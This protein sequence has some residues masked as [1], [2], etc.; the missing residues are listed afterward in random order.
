M[1][2]L[3]VRV[4]WHDNRWNGTVCRS[5]TGNAFCAS[6]DRIREEKQ[7]DL[8]QPLHERCF[9]TLS[10][11]E[12]P[13]CKAESG[14]FMNE[15][16]WVRLFEHP[17]KDIPKA[18]A[19]HGHLKPT[20]IPVPPYC[21]FAV[22]FWWML[23]SNQRAIQ[24]GLA[25]PLPPDEKA[26]FPTPWVFGRAR[27]EA[28]VELF[29][30]KRL[31][32]GES[33]ALFYCKAGHPLGEQI[34][35][36]IVGVGRITK[37]DSLR[38]YESA[39]PDSYP[40]WDR[41][42]RHSVR[43]DG[44][45]GF[46]LPYHDYLVPTGDEKEDERRARLLEEIVVA[47][48]EEHIRDFSY[49]AEL[50]KPSVA[51]T[52]LK[53]CLE[54]VRRVKEHG[55]AKGPWAKREDWLNVQI[56]K[57]WQDRGAFPGVGSALE[58]LGL[59]LG[60][61]M[62]LD[63]RAQEAYAANDDPWPVLDGIL[64]GKKPPSRAYGADLETV[65]PI[66][67]TLSD[68]RRALLK[69][70]SRFDLSPKQAKRWFNERDRTRA[71]AGPV[72]D[73][74]IL[75]NPYRISEDDLG[76]AGEL[77]V[78]ISTIDQ[79]LMPD[80]TISVKHPIPTPSA[81]KSPADFRRARAGLIAVLRRA[82]ENG[83]TLLSVV[84]AID[85]VGRLP[86]STPCEISG[87]WLRAHQ[88]DLAGM[89]EVLDVPRRPGAEQQILAVQL[90]E[91]KRREERLRKILRLRCAKPID[92]VQ[93][94]WQDLLIRA[95]K[96]AG[97][98]VDPKNSRHKAALK[99]QSDALAK[100][101][102][103]R[104]TVLAGRAGTGKTS[105]MGALFRSASLQGQGIL[106]LA[107]TGKAR[108]RLARA[109]G[110]EAQTV[111][112]FLNQ[113]SRYDGE[114]QRVLLDPKDQEKG[115][116]YRVE[117]TVVIDECSML[118]VDD[119]LAVFE[120]IDQAHVQRIVLVGDPNQLPPIGPGRPFADF[121]GFLR[122]C[123]ES[124]E[125]ETKALSDAL[126]ELTVEV[127]AA[128]G[129]PSD[130]LRLAAL[131]SWAPLPVDADRILA[132]LESGKRLND[133]EVCY[134]KT[135]EDLRRQL[136]GQFQKHLELTSD[137]DI[138]GFNRV[139]GIGEKG[140]VEVE[141]P[142]GA[143]TFQ[144]L[145]P[146]RMHSHGVLE[147]NRWVQHHFRGPE[148]QMARVG[149]GKWKTTRLG[150]EEIV[151]HDKV[152]QVRNGHRNGYNWKSRTVEEGVYLANGEVGVV[153]PA[154]VK[155]FLNVVFAG[156]R[157]MTFGYSW[158]DFDEGGGP[159]EL[160]YALTVHK[161]QGSDF[162]KVFVVIP[163]QCLNLTRELFY[164]ALTRSRKQLVLLV[165]GQ[166]ALRLNDFRDRSDTARRNTNLFSAVVRER[167]DEIPYA[168][169]LIHRT[170]KGHLVRSK[171]E[172]VIANMLF[173]MPGLEKY[174]YEQALELKAGAPPIH[175]DFSFTSPAGDRIV[176]EHLGMMSREDYRRSWENRKK[177]YEAAGFILGTTLFT[178]EDD[179]RGGLDSR[180]INKTA[181]KIREL[182]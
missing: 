98:L 88:R 28:L 6:L 155:D 143:E 104:V 73:A 60:T 29:F 154:K 94:P 137:K 101:V 127:R 175:P 44:Q 151:A 36:L 84:E 140:W 48:N 17:Y 32:E 108:V 34:A 130:A 93:E 49:A 78:S 46:L 136:L 10:A 118:T 52:T 35:R 99:E 5:P 113:R 85:R 69:L 81:V 19:T 90:A 169:H 80:S 31:R 106:L 158:R 159:L 61:A 38:R 1:F 63:L 11:A 2:H 9:S 86:L 173:H 131:F 110:A 102:A 30:E 59:R 170:E 120:A 111:A 145:S 162:D 164:T 97:G 64:R 51:L 14:A 76:S 174:E 157:L 124:Q 123:A 83:D 66:W 146:V 161:A 182:L 181:E 176:W 77:P 166:T 114:R 95:I 13:P 126:A 53:G 119:L 125:P 89:V 122:Q 41:L 109:T 144:I 168:D 70:L 67:A 100:L 177:D 25:E 3:S 139:L 82:A 40:M 16:E 153:N 92:P 50:V 178:S 148:L 163:K 74:D 20:R 15:R 117:K 68:E 128:A 172:L 115:K 103:R 22:P 18:A 156:R 62:C 54:A 150:D 152:I 23:Q 107:P 37:V 141:R 47:A 147:L 45:E 129:G 75:A 134:W 7:P 138:A 8:E 112:Q 42:I 105:V 4:A 56:S 91:T 43:P 87:D 149:N 116:P 27:Q 72:S 171:S 65:Q 96:D 179:E 71:I 132:D 12:L 135:P 33:L 26:P 55:L 58:A 39:K 160:A 24:E 21:T 79:G 57:A 180:E 165:E 167:T 133:L 142:D 121:V